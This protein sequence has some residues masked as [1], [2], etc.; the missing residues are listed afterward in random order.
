MMPQTYRV[1]YQAKQTPVPSVISAYSSVP[2]EIDYCGLLW[3][4]PHTKIPVWQGSREVYAPRREGNSF[5]NTFDI[6]V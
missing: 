6:Q 3:S 1:R 2:Y 5:R 4:G